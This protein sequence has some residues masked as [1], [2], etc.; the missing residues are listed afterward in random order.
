MFFAKKDPE[1]E[2]E[3]ERARARHEQLLAQAVRA[4]ERDKELYAG[5]TFVH[6][7]MPTWTQFSFVDLFADPFVDLERRAVEMDAMMGI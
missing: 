4:L 7:S 6:G 3:K 1:E 5:H 2:A